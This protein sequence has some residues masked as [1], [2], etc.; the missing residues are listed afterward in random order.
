MTLATAL[1]FARTGDP[2]YGDRARSQIMAAIGTEQVGANNSILS[3]GRQLGAYVLAADFIGLSGPDD[4]RFRSW[5]D[6]IR[7]RELGGHGRWRTL[8]GTHE[9]APNNWG[10]F[11]GASRIAASLYLGDTADVA[12]AAQVL[13]GFLGDR[14]SWSRFQGVE[15]A[16]SWACDPDDYTPVNPPCTRDGIDLDGAIV[17][18]I[19]RGGNRK[20][21]PG[22]DGIGYTLESL[23]GL[24]LQA[25]LLTVNGFGDAWTWSD[26]ALKRAAG[27][28]SRSGEAGGLTWNRSEVSYHVPWLLNARYGLD[29]PTEPAGFGRVFGYTDWL[30]GS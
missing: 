16:K 22:R 5:L 14:G 11:T 6:A 8:T 23:Q 24:S 27:I 7:T 28:V 3:L 30:Y 17:R 4:D 1:V 15:G 18:D 29:L 20:W 21:P 2:A 19:D 9:D 26:E 10:S 25:E 12:R 13:R